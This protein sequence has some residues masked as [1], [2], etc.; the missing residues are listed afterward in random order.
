MTSA[1]TNLTEYHAEDD[2][3]IVERFGCGCV[4]RRYTDGTWAGSRLLVP[5]AAP[6]AAKVRKTRTA[7]LAGKLIHWARNPGR[8][9]GRRGS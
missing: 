9:G 6:T 8:P 3:T 5:H 7:D 2:G 1:N 4:I